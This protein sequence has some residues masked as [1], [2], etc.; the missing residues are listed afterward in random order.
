MP[1][2]DPLRET[3]GFI[4]PL[5]LLANAAIAASRVGQRK[6]PAEAGLKGHYVR[7]I[8]AGDGRRPL[9]LQT[10]VFT[11]NYRQDVM[12]ITFWSIVRAVVN[13]SFANTSWRTRSMV[14]SRASRLVFGWACASGYS[15]RPFD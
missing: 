14:A 7:R 10:K 12:A 15:F 3:M 1:L 5:T 2:T 4:S 6:S 13:K 9:A 11:F 8:R